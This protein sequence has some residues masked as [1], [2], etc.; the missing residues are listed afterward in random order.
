MRLPARWLAA[1]P[2]A[3]ILAV[4]VPGMAAGS[5]AAGSAAGTTPPASDWRAAELHLAAGPAQPVVPTSESCTSHG[6][7]VMGGYYRYTTS[8]S[9]ATYQTAVVGIEAGWKWAGLTQVPLPAGAQSPDPAAE[10]TSLSCPVA[11]WCVAVGKVTSSENATPDPVTEA[12]V[13]TLSGGRWSAPAVPAAP[14]GASTV[15][16]ATWLSS[17]S[18]TGK[19]S[20]VAIGGYDVPA[21]H[22]TM[23]VTMS[24]GTWRRGARLTLSPDAVQ[25][26]SLAITCP[27]AGDCVIAGG[28]YTDE[29]D[30]IAFTKTESGGTWK[31]LARTAYP[32]TSHGQLGGF[33]TSVSCTAAGSCVAA[34]FYVNQAGGSPGADVPMQ[35]SE[36]GGR[37]HQAVRVAIS[38]SQPWYTTLNGVSCAHAFCMAAGGSFNSTG[39]HGVV[40][41]ERGGATFGDS[42][43]TPQPS[44]GTA[45]QQVTNTAVSCLAD[46]WCSTLGTYRVAGTGVSR[47]FATHS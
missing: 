10:V 14:A 45:K 40:F 29:D 11:G 35:A 6:N 37:W 22:R 44:N 16:P 43:R 27:K 31:T 2:A 42:V 32:G 24:H 41:T 1:I 5:A 18:C 34:G 12:F 47:A 15:A 3:A 4:T 7:C 36:S 39:T 25:P 30:E 13:T 17:V 20:C 46:G 8:G 28:Y 21:G 9:F 38:A 23:L 33:L 26:T 19:G